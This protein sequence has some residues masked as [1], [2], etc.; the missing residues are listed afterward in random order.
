M[1]FRAEKARNEIKYIFFSAD[2]IIIPFLILDVHRG[3]IRADC[4]N[5]AESGRRFLQKTCFFALKFRGRQ[6][7]SGNLKMPRTSG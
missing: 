7:I 3:R 1:F 2:S 4:T 6:E 5:Y